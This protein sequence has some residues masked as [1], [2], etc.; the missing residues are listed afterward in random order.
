MDASTL[1]YNYFRD[2]NA[3]LGRYIQSDPL[4]LTAG[5]NTYAYVRNNPLSFIDPNGLWPFGLPGEDKAKQ[6]LPPLLQKLVPTL[7]PEEDQQFALDIIDE[8]GWDDVSMAKSL[9]S[10]NL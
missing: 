10:V 7:T 8:L 5:I 1:N 6:Q 9:Q 4:G 3:T 2:Y